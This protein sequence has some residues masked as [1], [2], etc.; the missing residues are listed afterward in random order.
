METSKGIKVSPRDAE[1]VKR[2]LREQNALLGS[3]KVKHKNG[4]VFPVNRLDFDLGGL[5]FEVVEEVFE[6]FKVSDEFERVLDKIGCPLSSYDVVGDL[7]VLE[8]P[9]G[10][11]SYEKMMGEALLRSRRHVKA[12]FKKSSAVESEERVRRFEWIAGEKRTETVHR[13]HGCEFK[14]DIAK[15]FFSPRLSY[16]R[17]RIKEQ[18]KDGETI[19]DMFAGVGPYSIVLAKQRDVKVLGYDIN[20]HAIRY[21]KENIRIN[22][23]GDRVTA[24]HG[25]CR[26]LAPKEAADRAVMNLPKKAK[27]FFDAALDIIK[28]DGG[29]IHYYGAASRESPYEEEVNYIMERVKERGK[30]AEI[31]GKR[32]VR[33][34]SPGEVHV[35]IDVKVVL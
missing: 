3:K 10:F 12:V 28:A 19:V 16:E 24:V 32:V 6:D 1:R 30:S 8:I 15:V 21:F 26:E 17:Q 20:E 9:Q 4:V 25:D 27:E 13:E 35:A 29:V 7:A 5:S 11:A 14:V 33:S 18:V 22:K 31:T 23:V 2:I 34:Y